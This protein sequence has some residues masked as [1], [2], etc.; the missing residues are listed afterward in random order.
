MSVKIPFFC[1]KLVLYLTCLFG[2]RGQQTGTVTNLLL[3]F[4]NSYEEG[5]EN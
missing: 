4:E 2:K 3:P 1:S 5:L